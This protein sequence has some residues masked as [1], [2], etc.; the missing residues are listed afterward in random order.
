M[1]II[2]Y[3][4]SRK[5]WAY[6]C[7]EIF[8]FLP[9]FPCSFLNNNADI[10]CE[11]GFFLPTFVAWW[12]PMAV[13]R[14]FY[15]HSV[16]FSSV[17]SNKRNVV[18]QAVI[19]APWVPWSFTESLCPQQKHLGFKTP[20]SVQCTGGREWLKTDEGFKFSLCS[21]V[22]FNLKTSQNFSEITK[23]PREISFFHL[24]LQT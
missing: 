17:N 10:P 15:N 9:L 3:F 24:W 13:C 6:C 12:D 21:T 23:E 20:M 2:S 5:I 4:W 11:A 22:K 1:P 16:V 19:S 14:A 8:F 7:W 18:M